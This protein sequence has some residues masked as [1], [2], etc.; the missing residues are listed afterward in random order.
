MDKVIDKVLIKLLNLIS[1]IIN[2]VIEIKLILLLDLKVLIIININIVSEVELEIV[3][4]GLC[5]R[6]D[7]RKKL[8]NNR[9]NDFYR[10]LVD[11]V[12]DLK[13]GNSIEVKL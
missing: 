7:K 6:V 3:F 9:K 1:L 10:N 4:K 8:I 13:F 11:L 5:I 2:K 12:F